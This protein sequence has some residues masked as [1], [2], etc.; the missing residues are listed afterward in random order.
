MT[1]LRPDLAEL[2]QVIKDSPVPL[3]KTALLRRTQRTGITA[4]NSQ[5]QRLV[6]LS[7]IE[8]LTR[9]AAWSLKADVRDRV[10]ATRFY[11]A[12]PEYH[13]CY[14]CGTWVSGGYEVRATRRHWLRD[15]RPDLVQ[16]EPG[17]TCTWYG[18]GTSSH[19]APGRDCYA[20]Q[21]CSGPTPWPWT[22]EHKHFYKDGPM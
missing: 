11:R 18:L 4:L 15:C 3:S 8:E 17:P 2:L 6:N 1:G 9:D 22:D 14:F 13:N 7:E 21:D 19:A 20:Y 10:A 12:R 5:L 16:H